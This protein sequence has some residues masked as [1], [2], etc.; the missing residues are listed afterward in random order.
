MKVILSL[1]CLLSIAVPT[2]ADVIFSDDFEDGTWSKWT[3]EGRRNYTWTAD[4]VERHG[5]DMGHLYKQAFS[6]VTAVGPSFDYD[7]NL[8]FEFDMEVMVATG[9]VPSDNYYA[10]GM[11]EFLFFNAAHETVGR[12]EYVASTT[13]YRVNTHNNPPNDTADYFV[14][15]HA[16]SGN[17]GLA[18]YSLD[19]SD[20]LDGATVPVENIDSVVLS[21]VTYNSAG[22][23]NYLTSEVWVDNVRVT[24]VP[25][26][27]SPVLLGLGLV[28][29]L[30]QRRRRQ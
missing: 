23:V 12:V 15:D 17:T 24:T 6:E 18:S 30:T 28:G 29:F 5:S 21:F 11:A 26:P 20:L 22:P 8:K 25:E 14:T 9:S 16:V 4:V 13:D 7:P 3:I 19:M 10:S 1:L 27:A 2:R